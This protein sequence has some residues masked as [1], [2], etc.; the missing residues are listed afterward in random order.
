M[1]LFYSVHYPQP[2]KEDFWVQ[3][4][5][6][7]D[8]LIKE[9]PGVVFASDIFRDPEKGTLMG[10]TFW[11]SQEA[12]EAV[13]PELAKN[14]PAGEWEVKRPDVYMFNSVDQVVIDANE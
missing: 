4:M 2:G 8:E 1:F 9:Q 12:F 3:K 7:F 5:R 6:E 10:F 14:A 13:W 11:E